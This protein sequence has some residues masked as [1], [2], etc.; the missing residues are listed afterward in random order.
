MDQWTLR[1][2]RMVIWKRWQKVR[3]WCSWAQEIGSQ[4]KERYEIG[5]TQEKATDDLPVA[6]F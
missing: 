5:R 3:T 1:R 2:L 6:I 4:T